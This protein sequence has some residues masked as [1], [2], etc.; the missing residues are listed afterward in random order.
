L[1]SLLVH[2]RRGVVL[3][4]EV[5]CG[6]TYEALAIMTLLRESAHTAGRTFERVLILC[7][8]ALVRKWSDEIS[9]TRAGI[10]FRQYLVGDRWRNARDFIAKRH[11]IDRRDTAD[12]LR[13]SG[14]RGTRFDGKLQV[15]PGLYVVNH[16]LLGE[17][18]R[19]GQALLKHLYW[20]SWDLIIV[21]EAHHYAKHTQSRLLFGPNGDLRNYDQGIGGGQFGKILALTATP[22]ELDPRQIVDLLAL[23]RADNGDLTTLERALDIYAGHLHRFFEYR[24]RPPSD[25]ARKAEVATLKKLRMQDA[26]CDGAQCGLETLLRRYV[27][28]NTKEGERRQYFFVNKISDDNVVS[29]E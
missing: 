22:F 11:I 13:Q 21:D 4:D 3:A 18:R 19:E 5:G 14:L 28:R 26:T 9:T 15:H 8:P 16:N 6:K 7:K 12:D 24:S 17:S 25:E 23:V 20:T 27:I 2:D 29:Q 10:G 1:E